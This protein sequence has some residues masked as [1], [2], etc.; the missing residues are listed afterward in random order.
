MKVEVLCIRGCLYDAFKID[1]LEDDIPFFLT[2]G[3]ILMIYSPT[4]KDLL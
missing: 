2:G 1:I 4:V 3:I